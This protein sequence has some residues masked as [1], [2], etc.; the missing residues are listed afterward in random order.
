MNME[1][2]LFQLRILLSTAGRIDRQIHKGFQFAS[3]PQDHGQ[4]GTTQT[5]HALNLSF[6]YKTSLS[7]ACML[8]RN[9]SVCAGGS[10][11]GS[12]SCIFYILITEC[13]SFL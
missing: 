5:A 7:M 8:A 3:C 12:E 13:E 11:G 2:E 1:A 9:A 10:G 6:F 4:T